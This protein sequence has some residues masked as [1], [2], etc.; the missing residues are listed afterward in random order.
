MSSW[1]GFSAVGFAGSR[2]GRG[3]G[4][5]GAL[6]AAAAAAGVPVFATC[7]RGAPAAALAAAGPLGR[8]WSVRSAQWSRLP[9]RARFAARAGACVRAL[10]AA[11]APAL[12]CWPGTPAPAALRPGRSWRPCGSGSWSELALAAGLRVPVFVFLPPAATP[13]AGWGWFTAV[14]A[15][16]LAGS[17]SLAPATSLF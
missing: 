1:L 16:P 14:S 12:V 7:G 6:A 4:R 13:P 15:G 11:P 9:W 3:S 5:A 2:S 10:A 8:C 17:W